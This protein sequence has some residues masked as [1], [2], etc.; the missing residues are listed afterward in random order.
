MQRKIT[1]FRFIPLS[2]PTKQ[3]H[4]RGRRPRRPGGHCFFA[5]HSIERTPPQQRGNASREFAPSHSIAVE[6]TCGLPPLRTMGKRNDRFRCVKTT[7][8]L[9]HPEGAKRFER[10]SRV[11]AATGSFAS[12]RQT[13]KTKQSKNKLVASE[14]FFA[15]SFLFSINLKHLNCPSCGRTKIPRL[16]SRPSGSSSG[17]RPSLRMTRI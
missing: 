9:C 7:T 1:I 5:T 3:I 8:Q 12:K 11:A 17:I 6:E 14:A 10:R 4:C 13:E 16:P 2:C 15:A